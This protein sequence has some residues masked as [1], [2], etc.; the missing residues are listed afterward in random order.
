MTRPILLAKLL[1]P[2]FLAGAATSETGTAPRYSA[3]P[4]DI[5]RYTIVQKD[6]PA[7]PVVSWDLFCTGT[8]ATTGVRWVYRLRIDPYDDAEFPMP[9]RVYE[10][11]GRFDCLPD[12]TLQHLQGALQMADPGVIFPALPPQMTTT[13]SWSVL[14]GRVVHH[15]V[16]QALPTPDSP[17][18]YAS[19]WPTPASR[20]RCCARR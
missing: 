18:S 10:E 5:L 17:G 20:V 16:L 12:G 14:R 7:Q 15:G 6:T 9:P 8:N 11:G 1:L 13:S 4:G 19:S 3:R 2:V